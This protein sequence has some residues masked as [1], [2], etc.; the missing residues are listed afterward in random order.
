MDQAAGWR[1]DPENEAEERYWDGSAWTDHV[2]P[3]GKAI[4]MHLPEHVP[5]LQRALAAATFDIDAVEDRLSTLFDRTG[6]P[7]GVGRAAGDGDDGDSSSGSGGGGSSGGGGRGESDEHDRELYLDFEVD[8]VDEASP[9][10][11]ADEAEID[12][13]ALDELAADLDEGFADLDEAL[14][15][16]EPEHE[17]EAP[18]PAWKK[19]LFRRRS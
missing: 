19:G 16:E 4:V 18:P 15:A 7:S 17:R 6:T 14:A 2:R 11:A 1:T 12:A 9:N 13:S 10:S 8:E 3:A 5:E